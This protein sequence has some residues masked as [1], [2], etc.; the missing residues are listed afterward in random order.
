MPYKDIE[1]QRIAQA[2]WA[3]RNRSVTDHHKRKAIQALRRIVYEYLAEHPCVDC[4]TTDPRV[5]QFD[6]VMG[7][8][9]LPVSQMVVQGL[10]RQRVIDEIAKCEVRCANC[11]QIITG[12]RRR[13]Y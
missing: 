11:H 2:A 9:I 1:D 6:H 3:R 8:K 4:G 7:M 10:A 12:L 13:W 5:L